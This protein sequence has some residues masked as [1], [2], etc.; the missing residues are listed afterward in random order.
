M[1]Q[2]FIDLS[3]EEHG[4]HIEGTTP[5]AIRLLVNQRWE[6]NVRQL[7][8]VITQ[9]VV[10]A[11]GPILEASDIPEEYRQSTEIIPVSSGFLAGH[12]LDELEKVAIQQTLKLT[13]GNR[14]KAAKLLGIGART[15]YRK[16]KEYDIE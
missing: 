2:H 15:L 10:L 12:T 3:N 11:P 7:K 4:R 8:Q 16:L 9:M 13:D 5:E 14:E 6:G 1:I